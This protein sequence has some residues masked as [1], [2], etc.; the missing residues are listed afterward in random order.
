M[1]SDVDLIPRWPSSPGQGLKCLTGW[2]RPT[3]PPGV[4]SCIHNVHP[5]FKCGLKGRDES[6][7][8]NE[9]CID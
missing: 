9:F 8:I 4:H 2:G 5:A 6:K 7:K 3:Y 1:L